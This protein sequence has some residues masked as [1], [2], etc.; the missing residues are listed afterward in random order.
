[1]NQNLNRRA[2]LKAATVLTMTGLPPTLTLQAQAAKP[3]PETIRVGVIGLDG[4]YGE[5]TDA[6]KHLPNIRIT[7]IAEIKPDLRRQVTRNTLLGR[8][9]LYEDYRKLLD[10]ERLDLVAVCGENGV[11]ASVIQ[12][13]AEQRLPI[14]AEKP[15]ALS[16]SELEAVKQAVATHRVPLTMLLTMRGESHYQAIRNI[17][18]SGQIGAVV[19]ID[20]QKSYKLG[21]RPDWMKH[22]RSYGGTIPFIGIHMVDLMRWTSGREFIT[23]AAFQAN[24]GAPQIGD[25]EN[26]ATM[27]FRLDNQGTASLH[28]D[29]LRPATAA[30]HGDDR[31]RVVGTTG[32]VEYQAP[33]GLTL[34]TESQPLQKIT[35]LPPAKPLFTDFVESLYTGK[36]HFIT[37]DDIYRVTEIVLKARSAA[38]DFCVV[39]L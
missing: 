13:C 34:V 37:L 2:F 39:Q 9:T 7:A 12:A 10:Q 25:M 22:H 19:A 27:I 5:I 18:A 21:T 24:V 1:M 4:H 3:L 35:D 29:Y 23:A 11:R 38:T 30:T 8:A 33:S 15:L 17:I 20:A 36:P 16:L 32:I 6:A 31:L 26:T 14:V 28:L